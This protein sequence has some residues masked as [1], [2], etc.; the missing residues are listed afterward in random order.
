MSSNSR[1]RINYCFDLESAVEINC[2]FSLIVLLMLSKYL[3]TSH[4]VVTRLDEASKNY[5]FDLE[6]AVEKNR[7]F[8]LIVLLLL[9]FFN[10]IFE[11]PQTLDLE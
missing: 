11:C 1:F 9:S 2:E 8:P 4:I 3:V 5:C 10:Y 6:S 7:E